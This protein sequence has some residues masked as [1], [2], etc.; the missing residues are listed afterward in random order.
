MNSSVIDRKKHSYLKLLNGTTVAVCST[1]ILILLFAIII[2]FTG[3]NDNVI[4]PVNQVI[5]I[6]SLFLGVSIS[7]LGLKE[8][9]LIKGIIIGF[10]YYIVSFI[11]FSILQSSFAIN[12]SNF[13]DLLLTTVMG[14]LIGLIVVHIGK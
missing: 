3:I 13:Y 8:K 9:G 12:L 2:R 6:I 14:G 11:T 1:L 10:A 5:K 7:L 4:F